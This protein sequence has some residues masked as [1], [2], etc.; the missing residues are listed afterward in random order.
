M[1]TCMHCVMQDDQLK[2]YSTTSGEA[3]GMLPRR[4]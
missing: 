1:Y 2:V 3:A 4:M